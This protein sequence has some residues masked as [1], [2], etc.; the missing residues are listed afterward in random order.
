MCSEGVEFQRALEYVF[1]LEGHQ[2]DHPSDPG[3]RT[4]WGVTQSTY[5]SWLKKRGQSP[6]DVY[7]MTAT[8]CQAIYYDG[9]WHPIRLDRIA[10]MDADVAIELF[11]A[12]VNAGPWEAVRFAQRACNFLH[13]DGAMLLVDGIPGPK[14]RSQIQFLIHGGYKVALLRAMNG[15]QYKH[16][17]YLVAGADRYR[18][19]AR[20]WMRRIDDRM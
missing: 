5:D 20:G 17:Y 6:R 10:A 13:P 7:K 9:F 12:A 15:E 8:E 2:S 19:F 3:G 14:T 11:E 18:D 16:F 1:H 4:K